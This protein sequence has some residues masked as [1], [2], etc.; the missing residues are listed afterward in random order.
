[1]YM[2]GAVITL[3]G[4]TYSDPNTPYNTMPTLPPRINLE[5][6]GI[7]KAC[8]VANTALARMR[9][10]GKLIPNQKILISSIPLL[11][12][13]ASSGIENIFT[14][15]SALYTALSVSEEDTDSATKEVLRYREALS[16]GVGE[17][18]AG[19]PLGEILL[20]RVCSVLLN[21]EADRRDPKSGTYI[22]GP[23]GRVY[24]PPD[25]PYV[26]ES[27]I[28]YLEDYISGGPDPDPLIRLALIHYQFEAIHPFEDANGRCGRILNILY[29]ISQDLLDI[30]VLYLSRYIIRNKTAYYTLLRQVTENGEWEAWIIFMLTALKET[31][32]WTY[33]RIYAIRDLMEETAGQCRSKLPKI[34]SHDLIEQIFLQPYCK[35]A[36]LEGA[37]VG[38]RQTAMKYLKSLEEIGILSSVKIGRERI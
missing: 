30:P 33:E 31:A 13:T 18:K 36:Y 6:P 22:T 5:A 11:E 28:H 4:M 32:D 1:M 8:S 17:L 37:G 10:A 26:L 34:Y 14:T 12:A 29:L 3:Y 9:E 7:W 35:P 19:Q 23:E 38:N 24:T 27:L 21:H 2:E 25:D 16:I 15:S 20:T